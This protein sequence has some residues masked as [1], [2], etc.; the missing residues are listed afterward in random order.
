MIFVMTRTNS[1]QSEILPNASQHR[2]RGPLSR[3]A[4]PRCSGLA[5]LKRIGKPA[6]PVKLLAAAVVV[7]VFAAALALSASSQGLAAQPDE[8]PSG[9]EVGVSGEQSVSSVPA[10]AVR[11]FYNCTEEGASIQYLADGSY[12]KKYVRVFSSR[13]QSSCSGYVDGDYI[14][15]LDVSLYYERNPG[16][17]YYSFKRYRVSENIRYYIYVVGE[18][19]WIGP[20]YN[21]SV[22]WFDLYADNR[23]FQPLYPVS[24]CSSEGDPFSFEINGNSFAASKSCYID[25][26]YDFSSVSRGIAFE[27]LGAG[28][29]VLHVTPPRYVSAR[30]PLAQVVR[31]EVTQGIQDWNNSLTLVRNRRTV[32]R[33]FMETG[34]E[35]QR[36]ITARLKGIKFSADGR[37]LFVETTDP[38][39]PS[40]YITVS[41]NVADRRGDIDAS[42]NF[43]LPEHWTGL[44]ADEDLLLELVFD[45]GINHN[46]YETIPN[47]DRYNRC[48]ERIE[49][50]GVLTPIIVMVPVPMH[51]PGNKPEKPSEDDME[52]QFNRLVS[53]MPFD[54]LV[55]RTPNHAETLKYD[56]SADFGPFERTSENIDDDDNRED[57]DSQNL[58]LR[59]INNALKKFRAHTYDP[60]NS[61][62]L[63]VISGRSGSQIVGLANT[64]SQVA[65]WFINE[66]YESGFTG[67]ARNRGAHEFGHVLNQ[68]HPGMSENGKTTLDG[69][70]GERIPSSAEEYPFFHNFGTTQNEIWRPVLG[71]LEDSDTPIDVEVWGTDTRYIDLTNLNPEDISVNNAK[72]LAVINPYEV[73]S[74]MSYCDP[75]ATKSQGKW[76][77]AYH[78]EN[79][80]KDRTI[81][82]NSNFQNTNEDSSDTKTVSALFTGS[83]ILSSNGV[84]T[85]VELDAIHYTPRSIND[86]S[87]GDYTL[88]FRDALGMTLKSVSFSA[89]S[90]NIDVKPGSEINFNHSL[91]YADFSFF[92]NNPP[93]YDSIVIIYNDEEIA[94]F[95]SSINE[96][97]LTISGITESQVFGNTDQINLSW[98]GSDVDEDDLNYR[99]Y[100]SIDAGTT[101]RL[102]SLSGNSTS[103]KVS[104]KTLAGSDQARIG[105]SVSDGYRS[106]FVE[107]PIFSV[108]KH[109]PLIK[110]Q[111]PFPS[112]VFAESQ[113]F[114][115]DASGYD[116]E[117]GLLPSSAFT[118]TSNIDGNLGTGEFLVLSASDLTPGEHT[119]TLTATDSDNMT[120]TATVNITISARNMLPV[121]HNDEVFGGLE[122]TLLIDV[123]ANDIDTEGDFDLSS[124]TINRHPRLGIAEVSTTESGRPVIEYSPITGGEDTFAYSICDGLYRCDIAEVTVA[125]PDCTI[126]GTRGSDSLVGTSGDDVI[127]GLDG[128]DFIDGK[129]GNDLIYAGFGEDVVSGRTGDDT[130]YGGP[131]NDFILGHRGDDTIYGGLSDDILYG[132]GGNDTIYGGD[133]TDEVYGEAGNDILYGGYGPDKMHGGQGDDIIHGEDGD[134]TIRGNAGADTVY[135]GPGSDIVLGSSRVDIVINDGN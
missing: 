18:Y 76:M 133:E 67:F 129:A 41:S 69:V 83:V 103:K 40:Q 110:I 37:P 49:F 68:S 107:T 117:D 75:I 90:S 5:L 79:M 122:E 93:N 98:Q 71:P 47:D 116:V 72:A 106:L 48:V 45:P 94:K 42:L 101:Y 26:S 73:F 55:H 1:K 97:I 13:D 20:D 46:C 108:A 132:G 51:S 23:K 58:D 59:L 8:V 12:R 28:N 11:L 112:V 82:Y 38:V 60:A 88:N 32:V 89:V 62:F 22:V 109:V 92:V 9:L 36:E 52:E 74:V 54:H 39:N 124:L 70:C 3:L 57:N 105:V 120:A 130:I 131:G 27:Y 77:D 128:D 4:R 53:I 30:P 21:A 14:L 34:L 100:Y 114:L 99:L 86:S 113:G 85:G 31:L 33:A 127:C 29:P 2:T 65:S 43:I 123:L 78:Y 81:S 35:R 24:N 64:N 15:R 80:I 95:T 102:L 121:S 44:D 25:T 19:S 118:W 61:I 104:T 126:T 125:F 63:G 17:P 111:R 87:T 16:W 135:P 84:P 10:D 119:I 6:R 134:D 50:T 66:N 96:P 56:F 91:N 7:A 115:L